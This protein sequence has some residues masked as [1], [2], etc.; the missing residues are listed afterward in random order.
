M[1]VLS[2]KSHIRVLFIL[3]GPVKHKNESGEALEAFYR[4]NIGV[5]DSAMESTS[6]SISGSL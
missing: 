3:S 5:S 2:R 6:M 4:A 1:R